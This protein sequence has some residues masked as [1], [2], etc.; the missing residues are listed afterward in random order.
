MKAVQTRSPLK[1]STNGPEAGL[2]I[3]EV[4]IAAMLLMFMVMGLIPLFAGSAVN[5]AIGAD[6]TQLSNQAKTQ[7]EALLQMPFNAP[8][9]TL[10]N[11]EVEKT[12]VEYWNEDEERFTTTE[13]PTGTSAKYSRTTR[14]RQYSV[15]DVDDG[16]LGTP[17]PGGSD[18]GLVQLKEIE[19]SLTSRD[20]GP[21][22]GRP[23]LVRVYKAF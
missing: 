3:I 20:Y 8:D 1:R 2:S 5:N 11:G 15:S 21:I 12:T 9:L 10:D 18:P 16:V 14:I 13:P 23:L 22:P 4:L 19:V 7:A 17:L 6:A